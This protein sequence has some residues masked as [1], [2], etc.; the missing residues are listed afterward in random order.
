MPLSSISGNFF[1]IRILD[2]DGFTFDSDTGRFIKQP[3]ENSFFRRKLQSVTGIAGS[4]FA[5][6]T[7][8]ERVAQFFD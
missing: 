6:V 8:S 7:I 1:K 3:D 2:Y 5:F 4:V